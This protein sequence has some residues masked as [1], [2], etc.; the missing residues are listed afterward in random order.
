[1]PVPPATSLDETAMTSP[2]PVL[3]PPCLRPGDT[4]GVILPAGPVRDQTRAEQGLRLLRRM[5]YRLR[6]PATGPADPDY[7]AAPD[8]ERLRT[9]HALWAD[10]EVRA[11]MAMRGGYGCLRIVDRLDLD[12]FRRHPKWL[13]GFSDV[14]VLHAALNRDAGLVTMHGPMVTT[15]AQT[16]NDDLHRLFSLLAGEPTGLRH[17][18]AVEIL[19]PGVCRGRLTG[20]NLSCLLSLLG[21]PWEPAWQDA[22]VLLEDTGEP[23]YRLDRMLT[24]LAAAGRLRQAAGLLLG[25]FDHPSGD[26]LETIRLQEQVWQRVLELTRDADFPVWA[27]VPFGHGPR[28][29]ALPLGME[30]EM[31]SLTG[32][33]T[34]LPQSV[35]RVN[36]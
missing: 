27:N 20:G 26:T 19:R 15:L 25:G 4:I 18:A 6:L 5:G 30:A 14:T 8:N 17:T 28:N 3:L 16:E 33:L 11:L 36:G 10:E 31:N 9:L 7:L 21:T 29:A 34:L 32:T 1:M 35:H 22:I 12:V 2:R 23:M 13:I 24:Q